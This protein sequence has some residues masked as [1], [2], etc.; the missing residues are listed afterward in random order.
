M[1]WLKT[2]AIFYV[3]VFFGILL[4]ALLHAAKED[5]P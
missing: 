1:T 3:G 2:L 5:K 4:A